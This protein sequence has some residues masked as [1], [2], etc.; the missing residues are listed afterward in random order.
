MLGVGHDVVGRLGVRVDILDLD[1]AG[2]VVEQGEL[3]D[4]GLEQLP[5]LRRR[6]REEELDG[7][8]DAGVDA[9]W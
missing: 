6:R 7:H 3:L 2:V 5:V 8:A 1:D 4:L 9:S